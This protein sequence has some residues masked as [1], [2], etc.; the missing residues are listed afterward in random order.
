[1]IPEEPSSD[2]PQQNAAREEMPA[3][4]SF[5]AP[6]SATRIDR[7]ARALGAAGI[8]VEIFDDVAAARARVRA[9]IPDGASVFTGA[10]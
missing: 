7:T 6:A 4:W 3:Q 10:S 1:M 5:S 8:E 9:L 2:Q